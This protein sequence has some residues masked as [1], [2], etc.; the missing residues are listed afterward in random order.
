MRW[1][2]KPCPDGEGLM[3]FTSLPADTVTSIIVEDADGAKGMAECK[4]RDDGGGVKECDGLRPSCL[5]ATDYQ[6]L[7]ACGELGIRPKASAAPA[8]V[9]SSDD[10]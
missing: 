6:L 2:L 10:A 8:P 1:L 7:Q 5:V 4:S 9:C 3:S